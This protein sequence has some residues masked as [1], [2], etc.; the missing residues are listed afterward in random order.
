MLSGG[1]SNHKNLEAISKAPVTPECLYRGSRKRHLD[2]PPDPPDYV[3]RAGRLAGP[4]NVG[5]GWP[6]KAC[7]NDIYQKDSVFEMSCSH[8]ERD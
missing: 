8:G 6:L 1:K 5:A 7:G 4:D 3:V 2:S